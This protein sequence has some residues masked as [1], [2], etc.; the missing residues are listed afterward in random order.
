MIIKDIR[1]EKK[2][3]SGRMSQIAPRRLDKGGHSTKCQ[4]RESAL[5]PIGV[6][7]HSS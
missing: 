7:E 2:R 5:A 6:I 4:G 3:L 1:I